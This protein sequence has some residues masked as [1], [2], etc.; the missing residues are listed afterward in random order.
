MKSGDF[1]MTKRALLVAINYVGTAN[2]LHGC[3]NDSNNMKALLTTHGFA[4]ITQVLEG[5]AT[6]TGILTALQNLIT[7]AVPGD[8]IVFHYSGHGSQ[9][10]NAGNPTVMENIICPIDLNWLDKIITDTQLHDI[11]NQVPNGVN[12]T[13]I[14]DCCFSGDSLLQSK[15]YQSNK[16][17]GSK[18][19][20]APPNL[21]AAAPMN[22]ASMKDIDMSSLLIAACG[23]NQLSYDTVID[24]TPQG[25]ATGA[26]VKAV[27]ATPVISY[28]NLIADMTYFMIANNYSQTPELDGSSVLYDQVF[29]EPF[30]IAIA[31]SPVTT[32]P[33]ITPVTVTTSSSSNVWTIVGAVGLIALIA[34][35]LLT[36]H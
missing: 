25:A 36:M 6:T 21:V 16:A 2:E 14:M 35:V 5:A 11:F 3:I 9:I 8:V 24:G 19:I 18:F 12:T 7:G 31:P 34:A 30:T 33:T 10:P 32:V 4:D 15:T 29:A 28:A 23:V 20:Q 1:T 17:E 27:I 13:L 26:L 22:P